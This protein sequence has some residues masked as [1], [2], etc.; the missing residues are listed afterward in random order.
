M[1]CVMIKG[2]SKQYNYMYE[3]Y[4]SEVSYKQEGSQYGFEYIYSIV[5]KDA[6]KKYF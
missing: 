4:R 3:E 2:G 5:A 1:I 6:G